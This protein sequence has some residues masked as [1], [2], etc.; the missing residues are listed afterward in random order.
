MKRYVLDKSAK[1]STL[2]GQTSLHG[3]NGLARLFGQNS[4]PCNW[5]LVVCVSPF[6]YN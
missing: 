6:L 4:G 3:T 1:G 5:A 2:G